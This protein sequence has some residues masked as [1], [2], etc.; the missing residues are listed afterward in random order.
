[1]PT[2]AVGA[3]LAYVAAP[4]AGALGRVAL[5]AEEVVAES[6]P[7]ARAAV[8]PFGALQ[9]A[10]RADPALGAAAAGG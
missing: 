7:A 9:V 6:A 10:A 1:M 8:G 4:E 5:A 3:R 2:V